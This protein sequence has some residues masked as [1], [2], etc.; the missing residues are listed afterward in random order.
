MSTRDKLGCAVLFL[1]ILFDFGM[2]LALIHP[3]PP[4][5]A[6]APQHFPAVVIPEHRLAPAVGTLPPAGWPLQR[7]PQIHVPL[8]I[9]APVLHWEAVPPPHLGR[10]KLRPF[11]IAVTRTRPCNAR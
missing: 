10:G 11:K 9:G 4:V 3:K 1:L 8:M 6:P 2:L 7:T 5:V